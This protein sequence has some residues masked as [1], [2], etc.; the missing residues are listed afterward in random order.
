MA[1]VGKQTERLNIPHEEGQYIEVV[2]LSWRQM[3]LA[4]GVQMEALS[5][6]LK[7]MQGGGDIF[8]Q[9]GSA[10]E[11]QKA[12]PKLQYDRGV[13]LEA[14]IKAWSYDVPV[15]KDNIDLLDEKTAAWLFNAI[16]DMNLWQQDEQEV[17]KG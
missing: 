10:G 5:K 4:K 17:K 7:K 15:N 3:E 12:D 2:R 6:Q 11:Q 9:V 8:K 14:S 1:I 13:I 16:M